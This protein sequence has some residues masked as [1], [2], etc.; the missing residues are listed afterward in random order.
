MATE[1]NPQ[2]FPCRSCGGELVF[3]P[4]STSL[5][6]P[7]CGTENII[8]TSEEMKVTEHNLTEELQ[9]LENLAEEATEEET[10]TAIRCQGCGAEVAFE[11]NKATAE[12]PFCGTRV[13]SEETALH[14][15]KPHAVMP[16]S[17]TREKAR[18]AFK[19]W[20]SSR[21]FAPNKLKRYARS[22][23][24]TGVYCPYFTF[25]SQT[26]SRYTGQRGDYYYTTET[27][28]TTEDGKTVTKTRQVRHTRWSPASGQ[29]S[30]FF[31]D[32]LI[33]GTSNLPRKLSAALEPWDL[34]QLQPYA[35][36]YLSGF[37]VETYT[38]PLSRSFEEAKE[39]MADSI[40]QMIRRDIGGDE[41]R[42]HSVDT[43][44]SDSQYKHILLPLWISAYKF[45]KK[46]FRFLVNAQ[47][48]EVQGERPWSIPKIAAAVLAAAAV[49]GG[50]AYLVITYAQ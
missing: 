31:D 19:K 24:L 16:F 8:E 7:Y 25:D 10:A 18:E 36:E 30:H 17:I 9:R 41:Q 21:W 5:K 13:V 23:G 27:Y 6:C 49:I 29:V 50:I 35:R 48:G 44:Y 40:R 1:V 47:T 12:C 33:E 42:I 39:E 20:L 11:E 2:S 3:Q 45:R 34:R 15:L 4:G 37:S 32:V 38:K 43:V 14:R 22:S 46:T 28:T 26:Q